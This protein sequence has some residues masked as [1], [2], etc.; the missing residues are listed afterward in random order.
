MSARLYKAEWVFGEDTPEVEPWEQELLDGG[1]RS[2]PEPEGW[3]EYALALWGNT[4]PEHEHWPN[5]HKP[6][7][8][9]ST[10]RIYRSRSAAQ[11]RVD[12]INSWG[13]TAVL[14]ECEPAWVSSE[15]ANKRRAA[16]RLA[17]RIERKRAELSEL[18]ALR[19]ETL[20]PQAVG[21]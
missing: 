18:E 12:L 7:F 2:Q 1:F 10:N 6:F 14:V 9:P 20:S 4:P 17:K 8:F 19:E 11:R 5:G 16:A 15:V 13:G 3:R 21:A